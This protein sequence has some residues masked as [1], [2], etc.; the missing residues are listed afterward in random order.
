VRVGPSG[1]TT[2]EDFVADLAEAHAQVPLSALHEGR[3]LFTALNEPNHPDEGGWT[4]A[5][6]AAFYKKVR[7]AVPAVPVLPAGPS[8]GFADWRA[9]MADFFAAGG[10]ADAPGVTCHLYAHYADDLAY[11]LGLDLPV[12]VTEVGYVDADAAWF[13]D[14]FRLYA[15]AG[16]ASAQVFIAD[17]R[18]NGAWDERYVLSDETAR[19][20]GAASH[21]TKENPPVP[22]PAPITRE[23][24]LATAARHQGVP[25]VWG[26]DNPPTGL[27][28]SA[29]VCRC[30]GVPRR[31]T[32]TIGEF[33]TPIAKDELRPGDA[34]NLVTWKDPSG[35]GHIRLFEKWADAARTRCWVWE[36]TAAVSPGRVV[37]REIAYDDRY[38]P[39]RR[40]KV[41][42]AAAPRPP[43]F[44]IVKW[45]EKV[46]ALAD[47]AAANGY[48]W[49]SNG[50]KAVVALSKSEK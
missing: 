44:D 17:G 48:P 45:R 49:T 6:Y 10:L 8:Q 12:H 30:W 29:Y 47:E 14:R 20:I 38:Q 4:G 50:V 2:V 3:V 33:C 39:V 40:V 42:E 27:D 34:M 21:P 41:V 22:A 46:W 35:A 15:E 5:A 32:D 16:V 7:A 24:I 31:G 26:A 36:E 23:T 18:S 13:A 43:P 25:Y 28:C 9:W 1:R 19:A 11:W 37:H